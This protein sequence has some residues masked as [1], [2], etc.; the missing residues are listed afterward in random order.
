MIDALGYTFMQNA[1]IVSVLGAIACGIIGTLVT[2][3]RMSALAGSIA[4]ASFGGLGL[5][6]MAGF[7]PLLG[8]T[9]FAVASAVGITAI[10]SRK[11][12]R[13][14]T[15]MATMWAT[16]MA[17]GLV[18]IK[19]SGTYSADLMSWL[20]G[21][22]LAVS[23][24]DITFAIILDIVILLLITGLY[25][26]FLAV[27]FDQEFSTLQGVPTSLIRGLFLVLTALTA[28]LLM[29][30]TGLIMVIAMLSIPAAIAEMYMTSLW[31]M[32][33]LASV[34]AALFSLAGLWLAWVLDLPPGAVIILVAAFTYA[35]SLIVEKV[36]SRA[37]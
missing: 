10:S 17:A 37:A 27:S 1:V 31:K 18:F 8:A 21:S 3:N 25:K 5:A 4:H 32:M 30:I 13:T 35:V 7:D 11:R 33:I 36:R 2:V 23:A 9:G 26:E 16:G 34:L 19:L 12:T 22:L 29:K 20:F 15:A 28:V 6:Y 14:D 24:S